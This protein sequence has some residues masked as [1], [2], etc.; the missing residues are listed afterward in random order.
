MEACCFLAEQHE[1]RTP[2]RF[3]E[4]LASPAGHNLR[5]CALPPKT[6]GVHSTVHKVCLCTETP[7]GCT[8]LYCKLPGLAA[9]LFNSN[10]CE[11]PSPRSKKI[12]HRSNDKE[13]VN[14]AFSTGGS[15]KRRSS[16]CFCKTSA[17]GVS[18]RLDETD[19]R[20]SQQA[21]SGPNGARPQNWMPSHWALVTSIACTR[22]PGDARLAESR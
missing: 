3:D 8:V 11:I 10:S 16:S 14:R 12:S 22:Q 4:L 21:P 7:D 19:T 1:E 15:A 6:F 2:E 9:L 5:H 13:A 18:H 17:V 20:A